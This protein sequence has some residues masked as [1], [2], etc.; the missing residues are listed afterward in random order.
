MPPSV[1]FDGLLIVTLSIAV[2]FWRIWAIWW[3][4]MAFPLIK[5]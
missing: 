2:P 4:K 3:Q 5:I 1:L